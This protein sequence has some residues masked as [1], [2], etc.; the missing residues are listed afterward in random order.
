ML[1]LIDQLCACGWVDAG[2]AAAVL[3]RPVA[4]A[5]DA[6]ERLAAAKL[7]DADDAMCG[8]PLDLV[9]G[10]RSDLGEAVESQD[11]IQ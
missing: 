6:I 7:G 10:G 8:R 3:R 11:A 2:S 5:A 1:L 9:P 4:E